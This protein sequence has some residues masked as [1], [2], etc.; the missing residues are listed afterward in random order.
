MGRGW[1][2]VHEQEEQGP[3][4][5]SLVCEKTTTSPSSS[6][7]KTKE[8]GMT[9][10]QLAPKAHTNSAL[11]KVSSAPTAL[12]AAHAEP[13]LSAVQASR[14]KADEEVYRSASKNAH[15]FW[16]G[17]PAAPC[18]MHSSLSDD[19]STSKEQTKLALSAELVKQRKEGDKIRENLKGSLAGVVGMVQQL[20]A[21]AAR[22]NA[23]A[24][25]RRSHSAAKQRIPPADLHHHVAS[26]LS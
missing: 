20:K 15:D 18:P 22:R 11:L 24:A 7:A 6:R 4:K 12:R 8:L 10:C 16:F 2:Q 1:D 21:D 25:Q 26:P 5:Q 9:S 14:S 17:E 19:F 3:F 23:A 13:D